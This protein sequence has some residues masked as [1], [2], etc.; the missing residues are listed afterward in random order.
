[1]KLSD[2]EKEA[3]REQV[4]RLQASAYFS[5][6]QRSVA[7]LRFI[8]DH[9]FSGDAE[10]LKER[11][12]GIEVFG[13]STDYDTASD[14]VV[15]V[16]ASGIRKR[17]AQ[18]YQEPEHADE[19]LISL[20]SGAYIPEFFWPKESNN[21]DAQSAVDPSE[22]L[23]LAE[24]ESGAASATGEQTDA[25]RFEIPELE[26]TLNSPSAE[27]KVPSRGPGIRT[28]RH[29]VLKLSLIGVTAGVLWA[30]VFLI[31]QAIPRS[32]FDF[33]WGPVLTNSDP[34]LLCMGDQ[35][36]DAGFAFRDPTDP[37]HQV[38]VPDSSKENPL[39]TVT[40]DDLN[41]IVNVASILRSRGKKYTIQG[42]GTT[43]LGDLR[44]GP[45]IFVGAFDNAWTLRLT[46]HLRFHFSSDANFTQLRI[47][48]GDAQSQPPWVLGESVQKAK[49]TYRDYAI[50]AR[51]TDAT[52]GKLAIVIAGLGRGST[53]VAG[54]FLTDNSSLGQLEGAMRAAGNQRNM[55]FVLS[56]QIID[57][58]PGNPKIEAVYFW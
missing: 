58:Q 4:D 54:Q 18:Y 40:I 21:I 45:T 28:R 31:W 39:T 15:R 6:S 55:E 1:M 35:T 37:T 50:V 12:I 52:T 24:T 25:Q 51:F 13:R 9:T 48:D 47:I 26:P 8:I 34:V 7:F 43:S 42:E 27:P 53:L 10:K 57:G 17:L 2:H 30:G 20:H 33:F 11:T 14:P 46:G 19:P 56:T 22:T 3:I 49:G 29:F 5:Q 36:Q 41:A 23:L 44:A 16:T 32:A 38:W